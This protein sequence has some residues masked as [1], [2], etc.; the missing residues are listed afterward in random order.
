[1]N[2]KKKIIII[3]L[4][5]VLAIFVTMLIYK[6]DK[7]TPVENTPVNEQVIE[8]EEII[9]TIEPKTEENSVESDKIETVKK[10]TV[11]IKNN[12]KTMINKPVLEGNVNTKSEIQ[13]NGLIDINFS[14]TED[15]SEIIITKEYNKPKSRKYIFK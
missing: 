9:E 13:N 5:S 2:N 3:L 1:M 10:G 11:N 14:R 8:Q 4:A 12:E 15:P 6:S 7:K